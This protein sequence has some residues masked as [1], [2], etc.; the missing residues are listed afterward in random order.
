MT[1]L[2]VISAYDPCVELN[3]NWCTNRIAIAEM[4]KIILSTFTQNLRA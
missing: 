1:Y 2:F 4:Q 3:L